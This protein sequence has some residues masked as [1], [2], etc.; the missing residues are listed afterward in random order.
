[1]G[2][3]LT[4]KVYRFLFRNQYTLNREKAKPR[5][6]N[7]EF[8]KGATNI[9]DCLGPIICD[10]ML[11]QREI[12][13]SKEQS[14]TKH[15]MTVGSILGTEVYPFDATVW[16]SG[17]HRLESVCT[18]T[19]H[20]T[21][22]KL[23]IRAVRGPVTQHILK[24]SG[25]RCPDVFGDPAVLMPLIY[26]PH[27]ELSNN[28]QIAIIKHFK[29]ESRPLID[30]VKYIDVRT[31]NYKCFIDEICSSEKVISS[32][33]HGIILA[34]AYGVPAVFLQENM[35]RELIKYYDWYYAT[36]RK[37][38]RFAYTIEE[39]ILMEMMSVPNLDKMREALLQSFPYDLWEK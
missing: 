26:Q 9:G 12:N 32:S 36:G 31:E 22:R 25:F 37:N 14:Q 5:C 8:W 27:V 6:V 4:K 19:R 1:M 29:D 23:D 33:L 28:K 21:F 35:S 17:I 2:D 24:Y 7:I 16:G 3:G 30:G 20:A 39:A 11:E 13:F 10:W 18:L 34:E 38:I 15:L